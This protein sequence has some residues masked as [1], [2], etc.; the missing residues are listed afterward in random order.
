MAEVSLATYTAGRVMSLTKHYMCSLFIDVENHT[1]AILET[2][3]P[4]IHCNDSQKRDKRYPD[5]TMSSNAK[6]S[7]QV[8]QVMHDSLGHE[9][10][11]PVRK[12]ASNRSQSLG[13]H[14]DPSEHVY[15]ALDKGT[16]KTTRSASLSIRCNHYDSP[17]HED[18]VEQPILGD[19]SDCNNH[20][21]HILEQPT[22]TQ[23]SPNNKSIT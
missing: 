20:H 6:P 21:Y 14:P 3:Q 13:H 12:I 1:Y 5:T 15:A 4:Q 10:E 8:K 2:P 16:M 7:E 11:A 22:A 17:P 23:H 19:E 18:R 9:Y